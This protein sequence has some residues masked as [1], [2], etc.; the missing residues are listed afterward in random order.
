MRKNMIVLLILFA[1]A[2]CIPK[3]SQDAE[4]EIGL[5]PSPT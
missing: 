4:P 3:I 5:P 2:A 1:L